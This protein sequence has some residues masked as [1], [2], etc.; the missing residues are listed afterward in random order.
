MFFIRIDLFEVIFNVLSHQMHK[1]EQVLV[2]V[3]GLLKRYVIMKLFSARK[4]MFRTSARGL[5]L[6]IVALSIS[7]HEQTQ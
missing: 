4:S 2:Y 5:G 6:E 3:Q 7:S 1:V